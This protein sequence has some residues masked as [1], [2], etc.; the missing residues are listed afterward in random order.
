MQLS[1]VHCGHAFSITAD[2]LG[3]RGSCPHCRGEIQL[4]R[5][6]EDLAEE[7]GLEHPGSWLE[8]SISFMGSA[9]FHL[10]LLVIISIIPEWGREG[11]PGNTEQVMIGNLP[12]IQLNE[13]TNE[14]LTQPENTQHQ[15]QPESLD[16]L[17][18][19]EPPSADRETDTLDDFKPTTVSLSGAS[20]FND[21]GAV[22]VSSIGGSGDWT[23]MIQRLRRHGLDVVLAFDS[24]GS[25][26]GE[27]KQVKA[28]IGRIGS[29]LVKLVPG[30]RLSICTYRDKDD[31]YLVK[32]L[33]LTNDLQK[34]QSY[35]DDIFAS[36]GGDHEEAVQ[37]GL[38]WSINKNQFRPRSRK[39]ILVFGDAPPHAQDLDTCK[40]LARDFKSQHKGVVS[41]VTCRADDGHLPAFVEI[42]QMGGG[43]AFMTR[44]KRQ[45]MTQI[46]VLVFGSEYRSKVVEAFKLLEG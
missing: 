18:Q 8:N 43:E 35:L 5:A 44:D 21:L 13:P 19:I 40:R 30:T 27:I 10:I 2:Q 32:G 36:G 23:G 3:G 6:E 33:P 26:G 31:E 29:A 38:Y 16:E 20:S 28:H 46:M 9:I 12:N 25:M 41:T 17:E 39:V 24:T 45:I 11:L 37:E 42:A 14:Q 7:G 22:S 4:P 15:R 1:C 34:V